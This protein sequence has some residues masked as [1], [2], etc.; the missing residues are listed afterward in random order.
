MTVFACLLLY[1][2]S[3]GPVYWLV[4][5]G[6][7][8]DGPIYF[9]AYLYRPLWDACDVIVL[10]GWPESLYTPRQCLRL[11]VTLFHPHF[12]PPSEFE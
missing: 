8:G 5:W 12:R 10:F 3:V 11:Y 1:V 7:F 6:A 9:Q 2:I 4:L